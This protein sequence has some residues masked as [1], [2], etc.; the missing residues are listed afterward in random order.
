MREHNKTKKRTWYNNG[1]YVDEPS[2][3]LRTYIDGTETIIEDILTKT[4]TTTNTDNAGVTVT[5]QVDG[6]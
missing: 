1:T 6:F 2:Y 5:T 3:H 4:N